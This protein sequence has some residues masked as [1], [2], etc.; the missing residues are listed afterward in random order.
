MARK[1]HPV[2]PAAVADAAAAYAAARDAA[3][4]AEQTRKDAAAALLAAMISADLT[5]ASTPHGVAGVRAGKR[6]VR[7]TDPALAAEIK[8]LQEKGVRTGRA[9]ETIGAPHVVLS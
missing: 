9:A 7:V 5:S 6:T 1:I 4:A 2:A 3:E 8:L